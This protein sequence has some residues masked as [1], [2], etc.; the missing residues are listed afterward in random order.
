MNKKS[1]TRQKLLDL[2]LKLIWAS[3]YG[4]VTVDD[5]CK[6]GNISKSSF[7]HFFKSKNE[8]AVAAYQ[9]H[10]EKIAPEYDRM[11]SALIPPLERLEN[12]CTYNEQ[13]MQHFVER[14]GKVY[15]CPYMLAG[16]ELSLIN[17]EMRQQIQLLFG[18]IVRYIEQALRDAQYEELI[19]SEINP[20]TM[21]E[22]LHA[23]TLGLLLQAKVRNDITLLKRLKPTMMTMIGINP[24]F[25]QSENK[26]VA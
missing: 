8:L 26:G 23:F 10:W 11:F 6:A 20:Q 2:A 21:A 1:N 14:T 5:I 4:N 24:V 18:H 3:S 16:A 9:A 19:S 12:F 7:Y 22:D 15:G 13:G 25:S 17:E